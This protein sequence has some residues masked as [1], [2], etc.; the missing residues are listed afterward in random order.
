MNKKDAI[1]EVAKIKGISK[2]EVYKE[3]IE[4]DMW[5]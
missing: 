5:F 2:N 1:K 4:L 3:C